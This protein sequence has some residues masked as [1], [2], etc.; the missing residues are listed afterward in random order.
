M[1]ANDQILRGAL[2]PQ[3]ISIEVLQEKYAKGEE[4]SI[5]DVRRRVARALAEVEPADHRDTWAARF[6]WALENGF[7]PAGRINSAAGTGIQATLINCFVQPV[8]DSVSES[9]DGK[10]SIYTAVAQ[11]AETM[12]R[13]G[14]VGYDFSSIRPGGALVRATHSRASGPVSF[15]KVFDASCA[16]VESA[17]SRRGAQMGVLRCDHPDIESFIHA[18]DR[19]D[20]TNFN[21]SIGVTD[22]F[23]QAVEADEEIE[24]VHEAEPGMDV[25][26]AGAYRRD[27]GQWV[28]RRVPAR[29]L[30]DQVMQATYDHAEPG[31]LFLSRINADNNLYY[32]ETIE[33]TNPCAEQPLPSYGCCCLG[34]INLT[35][36]VRQ[37]FTDE[38][39][40][41]FAAF[42]EVVRVS[43]RMLDNVL[44]VTFWPL[45]EQ[46]AE[47]QAKRRIGLGFLGLGSALVMLGLRYDTDAAR[48]L[49]G[50]ISESM[51]DHAYLASVELADEKGAFPLFD[52]DAYLGGGF[53]SR[54]PE[55]VRDAIRAHGLRNSHLLSI[56]PTGTI[57]L[58]FA[59]NASNGIE[60][61]FSWTYNRRKRMPDDSYRTFEV[62]DHA[63]RLY[64]HMG[65]D[66]DQL[67]DSFVTALQMS[68]LDH[69]RMLEAVQ[70]Y[71]DTSIS[72]TVNVPEDYP[73]EAFRNLYL[74]AWKAGLKGLATYRPNQVLGAV[75]S[76]APAPEAPA[77]AVT[78]GAQQNGDDPLTR[79]FGSRP[80]GDLEGVTS[81]VEY[82]TYE[83]HKTVYL[84]VNFMRVSGT[85][86]GQPVTIE[87]PIEFFMPAGQRTEGQQW[88]T[89]TMRLLSMVARSGGPI[90]KAL[91]DMRNVVW[92]KGTVRYGSVVRQD[93]TEV[94]RFHDSEVAALSYALQ[95][96][97]IKRG[98]LD[99]E[100]GQVPVTALAARLA[101]R[102]GG[103]AAVALAR[104]TAPAQAATAVTGI[105]TGKPCPECGAHALHKVDG[106][107]KC[108]NCGY[109]GECG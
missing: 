86:D 95:R 24:L 101:R 99:D 56:A 22:A 73:Y 35:R 61:A 12:R 23:M 31:I 45:P 97:L 74:E 46:Q 20:L 59:D 28:Y 87:R 63:W 17:G 32:C 43:T 80:L 108:A 82:L 55:A 8:G 5:D 57:T 69:M 26:A 71:I 66:M 7:V 100:G 109:V 2:V 6:L 68:A 14:G 75:L 60:P 52:A 106:C 9:R 79:P 36:F 42:A 39:S 78:P 19:G 85:V 3:D 54:L 11:A 41:D 107:A 89:S 105:G 58:A 47:A 103:E 104:P 98:F 94:P 72:K 25:I 1:N 18:K 4:R 92:D 40:F 16:T 49:A 102:D 70:P 64:R 93:G 90:A 30:W 44:D 38:A 27:D 29:R 77:A 13:G 10:P 53:V 65:G 50:R 15:M 21:I 88:I 62:A 84:T 76:V 81:K 48:A 37:P 96:I 33:A 34:S 67:P 91:A 51:R 83:G